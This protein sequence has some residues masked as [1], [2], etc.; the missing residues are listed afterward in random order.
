MNKVIIGVIVIILIIGGFVL[1]KKPAIN[2][3][4]IPSSQEPTQAGNSVS[5]EN[6]SFS[7]ATLTVKVGDTVTWTNKDTATHIIKADSFTSTSLQ[8]NGVYT[9]TFT[10]KGTF[11]YSCSI[12]PSMKG[13]IIVE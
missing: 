4:A 5:I 9:F 1:L 2:T 8:Q 7:P 12:H 10:T 11:V 3:T 6:F 13:T